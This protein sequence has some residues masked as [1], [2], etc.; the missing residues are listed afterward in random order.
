MNVTQEQFDNKLL[1][2]LAGM[3]AACIITIPGVYE[4]LAEELNNDVLEELRM[5]T[6]EEE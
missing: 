1:E 4:I 5:D 2:I 6:E 3:T